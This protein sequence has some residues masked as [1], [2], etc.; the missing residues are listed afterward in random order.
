MQAVRARSAATT[1]ARC[2]HA[3]WIRTPS[4]RTAIRSCSLPPGRDGSRRSPPLLAA[5]AK[6]DAANK[7]G[8]RP[9]GR[10]ARRPSGGREGAL[11][12]RRRG[13][14]AGVDA[15]DLRRNQRPH[16]GRRATCSSVGRGDRRRGAVNGD[17][18]ADDGRA[19]R[20][21][22][23]PSSCCSPA[24]RTSNHSNQSGHR[25]R[26]GAARRVRRHREGAKTERR[27]PV[28]SPCP[29]RASVGIARGEPTLG[30]R[31]VTRHD[32]LTRS[33]R[34]RSVN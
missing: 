34:P 20:A 28:A 12:A 33:R 16:R 31:H 27:E 14:S 4:T 3:G 9:L 10:G 15:A 7:F 21:H 26:L 23:A 19:R 32:V 1:C 8:D 24:V 5:G 17:D 29:P 25:A 30:G 22:P 2:S 11:H 13:Q 18:R 6:V